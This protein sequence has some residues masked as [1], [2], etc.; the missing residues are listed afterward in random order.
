MKTKRLPTRNSGG[1]FQ[2]EESLKRP[3]VKLGKQKRSKKPSIYDE[4]DEF[5]DYNLDD[6][7]E[8]DFYNDPM[9]DEDEDLY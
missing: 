6:D 7:L 8:D 1:M 2:D 3:G 4:V 9:D 5:D